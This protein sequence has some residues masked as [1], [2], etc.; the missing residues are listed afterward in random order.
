MKED[1]IIFLTGCI[2]PQGMTFTLLGNPQVRRDQYIK[3]INFYIKATDH[4]ILFV[5]NSNNDISSFFENEIESG[6]I[7]IITFN[8][9]NY[10]RQLGK[11]YGE[12]EIIEY[13]FQNSNSIKKADFIF[14]ITGRLIVSN[15][16]SII[17]QAD[18]GKDNQVLVNLQRSLSFS[19]SRCWGASKDF[20]IN[21]IIPYKSTL[22]DSLNIYF[23][24]LLCKAVHRAIID[25]YN[26]SFLENLPRYYGTSATLNEKYENSIFSWG[27]LFLKH[28]V[29][30]NVMKK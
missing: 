5:E 9:N 25:D 3:A 18:N 26:F 30:L 17:S 13:A 4:K 21:Y 19:D 28:R 1:K 20:F 11:G 22:N 6:R 29:R 16:R 2:D 24:H 15:I 7:E 23:E 14:K 10:D 8:G 27:P 12:M